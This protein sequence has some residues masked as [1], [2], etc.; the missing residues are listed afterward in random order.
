MSFPRTPATGS[1]SP[2]QSPE[3]PGAASNDEQELLHAAQL[4]LQGVKAEL[5][6]MAAEQRLASE[7]LRASEEFKSRLI[8]CSRDC[9]KILDLEGRI[10]FMNPAGMQALEIC[11]ADLSPDRSWIDFWEGEDREAARAAVKEAAAGGTGRCTGYFATRITGQSR[12]LD[13]VVS[14]ILDAN[15]RPERLLALSRDITEHKKDESDLRQAI[16]FN[17]E[18]MESAAEGIIVYDPELRYQL[19]NPFMERLTGRRAEEVLGKVATDVFPRLIPSGIEA[20][21][22]RALQ[23]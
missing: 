18:I 20:A 14:P 16:Q 1:T 11:D 12:W 10:L 2:R 5:D 22:K 23:G 3:L 13:V 8:T 19:W 17:Q 4:E 7:S 15:G 21:L 6:Q 9:I